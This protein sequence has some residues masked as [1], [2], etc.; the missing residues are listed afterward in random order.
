[1][2]AQF[3]EDNRRPAVN[4]PAPVRFIGHFFSFVFHPLFMPGYLA[5][6]LV[7]VDAYAYA[8]ASPQ[9]KLFRVLSVV[10]STAFLP[11]FCIFLLKQLGFIDSI[12]LRT[13]KDRIIP[14]IICMTWYFWIWYVSKN[15]RENPA[16]TAM[17]LGVFLASIAGMMANI[18]FKISMHGLAAGCLFVFF[19]WL[20]F[21]GPVAIG[22]YLAV[23]TLISGLMLTARFIVSGHSSGELYAGFVAGM[24]CQLIAVAIAG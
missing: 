12:F 6:Y 18:Y 20:A 15:L 14:Y 11:A 24:L 2:D 21:S 4:Y 17:L 3:E 1:M 5:L 7:Y 13:R 8:N 16:M 22:S 10:F 9:I 23:A 19:L